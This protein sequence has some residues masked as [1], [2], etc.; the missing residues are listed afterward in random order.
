MKKYRVLA[1]GYRINNLS[2]PVGQVLEIENDDDA[3]VLVKAGIIAP[4][5][6]PSSAVEDSPK[7]EGKA[8]KKPRMKTV[9]LEE[10][11]QKS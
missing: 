1:S 8:S 9:R 6:D 11:E 5:E 4:V 2:N 7:S 10:S 3:Q